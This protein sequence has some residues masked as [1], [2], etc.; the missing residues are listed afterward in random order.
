MGKSDP[1]EPGPYTGQSV[2][3]EASERG[4]TLARASHGQFRLDEL[5]AEPLVKLAMAADKIE[6][7]MVHAL[8]RE[9]RRRSLPMCPQVASSG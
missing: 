2:S 9:V 4:C 3:A 6:P 1:T 5:L 7:A 8:F